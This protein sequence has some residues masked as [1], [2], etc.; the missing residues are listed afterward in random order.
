M[1]IYL[2]ELTVVLVLGVIVFTLAKPIALQFSAESD[3]KRRRNVW[4]VLTIVALLSP[5]IWLF[6][7]AALPVLFWAGRKDSNPLAFYL[8]ILTVVP[9][10]SHA[11][12]AIG[13][14]QLFDIDIFRVLS[15][16]VLIPA[17]WRLRKSP[18]S[19]RI[20]GLQGMDLLL[21]AYG[22]LEALLYVAPDPAQTQN[23]VLH[24]SYT[25]VIREAF[26]FY[27]DVYVLYYV[28]SRTATSRSAI[29]EAL[30][31]FVLSCT[32]M[33]TI[34]V[35]ESVRNWLLYTDL[36]A[37]WGGDQLRTEYY[38]RAGLLRAE[39]SSGHPLA[40]GFLLTVGFGLW[41]YLQTR[42]T[43]RKTRKLAVTG[44]LL[45]GLFV[46]FSRGPWLAALVVF[47]AH[48]AFRPGKAAR[49]MKAG[50]AV[51][52]L[53]GLVLL[54]PLGEQLR[55]ILPFSS[56][57]EA[58]SSLIYRE[59]LL[60]ESWQIIQAHPLFGDQ[61]ALSHMQGLRQGQGIID[62][63]NTYLGV[64]L[65]HGF[66]G[67]ALFLAF[68]L[69][70][71]YRMRRAAR[72]LPPSERDDMLLTGAISATFVGI[73]ILLADGGLHYAP[74]SVFYALVGIS[75]AYLAVLYAAKSQSV[76]AEA[77]SKPSI[78]VPESH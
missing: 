24:N 22:A 56:G 1:S 55:E 27:V 2:K 21:L 16:S 68:Q 70:P 11:L 51:L 35:F 45:A 4:I 18:D 37:L 71:L 20:R 62:V 19:D 74:G 26:L 10:V 17:A 61:L 44:V 60:H 38:V 8:L 31:A 41:L 52:L 25:N 28:A 15:F 78:A 49:V 53:G 34:A 77:Q 40:L 57:A 69:L 48:A 36:F 64:T 12:P 33:A 30:A 39:A 59:E 43:G 75:E 14:H 76:P 73:I 50:V 23:V 9:P 58:Q 54:S 63:V 29:R 67:L 66:A 3:F 72:Q 7:L 5:S 13:S 32:V 42:V 47:L 6:A 65:Y 46:S